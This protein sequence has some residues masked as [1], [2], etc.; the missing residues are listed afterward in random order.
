[1]SGALMATLAKVFITGGHATRLQEMVVLLGEAAGLQ[2]HE[3]NDLILLSQVHDIGKVG[4]SD[5]ILFK[6][7]KLTSEEWEQMKKHSEIGYR[8]ASSSP[9][10]SHIAELILQHHEWWNGNGYPRGLKGEKIHICSRILAIVD[11]Y[12]AMISKRPYREPCSHKEALLE[13]KR[14]KGSQFDPF[15]VDLFIQCLKDKVL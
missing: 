13:L 7:G 8:I 14:C 1:M 15:L 9:E 10:L 4:I 5:S 12:D 3:L 2:V 11:A 6:P